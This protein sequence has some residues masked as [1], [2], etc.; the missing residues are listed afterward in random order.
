MPYHEV[1][2]AGASCT[3]SCIGIH[4]CAQV[5]GGYVGLGLVSWAMSARALSTH[6]AFVF[7][8]LDLMSWRRRLRMLKNIHITRKKTVVPSQQ[9]QPRTSQGRTLTSVHTTPLQTI[10]AARDGQVQDQGQGC[11]HGREHRVRPQAP[12]RNQGRGDPV[13]EGERFLLDAGALNVRR[14]ATEDEGVWLLLC[15]AMCCRAR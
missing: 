11:C 13:D 1:P 9:P 6:G 4:S 12:D 7:A 3:A 5:A 2:A 10:R 15:V 14:R 8:C